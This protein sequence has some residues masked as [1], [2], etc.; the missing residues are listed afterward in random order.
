MMKN[1]IETLINCP[2]CGE[3]YSPGT[4]R[5]IEGDGSGLF[6][7]LKC[8]FCEATSLNVIS[9]VDMKRGH[10]VNMVMLT[11]LTFGE[12]KNFYKKEP[13]SIDEVIDF[14]KKVEVKK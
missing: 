12:A 7:H 11:D 13:I 9:R 1:E 6:F 4:S 3:K 2:A 10:L 8:R 14:C 5:L